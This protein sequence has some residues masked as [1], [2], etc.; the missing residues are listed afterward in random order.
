MIVSKTYS[1]YDFNGMPTCV[2]FDNGSITD[3]V[4]TDDG[5]NSIRLPFSR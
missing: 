5:V 4:Y 2:W 3:Y 1:Q